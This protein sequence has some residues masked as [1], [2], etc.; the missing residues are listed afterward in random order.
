MDMKAKGNP[1]MQ[2]EDEQDSNGSAATTWLNILL[3]CLLRPSVLDVF[4]GTAVEND[5]FI[6]T[7]HMN[8]PA[9]P[10]SLSNTTNKD[11]LVTHDDAPVPLLLVS[12]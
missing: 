5:G 8:D 3:T 7:I 11:G 2:D 1:I 10:Y 4:P 9:M 6:V 12:K